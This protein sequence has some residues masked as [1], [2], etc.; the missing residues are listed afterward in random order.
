MM[1]RKTLQWIATILFLAGLGTGGYAYWF[2]THS[3]ENLR[4]AVLKAIAEKCPNADVQ[5]RRAWFDFGRRVH[6]EGVLISAKGLDE[7]LA[8]CAEVVIAIDGEELSEDLRIDVRSV[9]VIRP[10]VRVVRDAKGNWN[11]QKLLPLP[12]PGDACPEFALEDLQVALRIA[13]SEGE[14]AAHIQK[15]ELRLISS[16]RRQFALEASAHLRGLGSIH[17]D[18]NCDLNKKTW[19]VNGQ[20]VEAANLADLVE[21]VSKAAPEVPERVAAAARALSAGSPEFVQ[22]VQTASPRQ[23]AADRIVF[24]GRTNVEFQLSRDSA[25]A[26]IVYKT[27]LTL[28][29]AEVEHPALPFALQRVSGQV[30]AD[31]HRIVIKNVQATGETV[32][33][34]V[35]G[36]VD[37]PSP[38]PSNRLDFDVYD[39]PLDERLQARLPAAARKLARSIHPAGRID[40]K[41]S[42]VRT[43]RGWQ[44]ANWVLTAKDCT[45]FHEKFPYPIQDIC[46]KATQSGN[47]FKIDLHGFGGGRPIKLAG[48][49]INP[50]AEA[51]CLYEIDVGRVPI[52]DTLMT[53]AAAQ[54]HLYKTLSALRLRGLISARARFHRPPGPDK[55]VEWRLAARVINGSIEFE[56]FPY[57]IADLTGNVNF[58]SVRGKWTFTELEGVHGPGR[59]WGSGTFVKGSPADPGKLLL[60]ISTEQ[61]PIENDLERSF[62]SSTQKLWNLIFPTGRLRADV[63][64]NWT[65]GS[66]AAVT[67]PFARLTN[68]TLEIKSFPYPLENVS[69]RFEF[70]RD[71]E[72]ACDRLTILE[73]KAKHDGTSIAIDDER[74]GAYVLC[75][76]A[77]DP[78]GEWQ[79]RLSNL[80]VDDLVPDRTLQHALP[81][82][83]RKTLQALQPQGSV[84]LRG[85]LHL[86]GTRSGNYP[87]TAAWDYRTILSG[88][89]IVAGIE[90]KHVQGLVN[91]RGKWDGSKVEMD[92]FLDLD[93]VFVL[94][95]HFTKVKGPFSLR[96]Q[97]LTVGSNRMIR[98]LAAGA[99]EP[100]VPSD[101][102]ISAEAVHG[103]FFLDAAAHLDGQKTKYRVKAEM[104]NASLEEYARLNGLGPASLRGV[105]SGWVDLAGDSS[106]PKDVA[107][108]GQLLINP[109]A[110]YELPVFVQIFKAFSFAPPD[111]TAFNYALASYRIGNRQVR[112]DGIDLIG[113]ALSLRGRGVARFD[114][115]LHLEFYSQ[116]PRNRWPVIGD[117]LAPFSKGWLGVTVTGTVQN[118][119]AKY[120]PIPEVDKTLRTFLDSF[121]PRPGPPP[122]LTPSWMTSVPR[123]PVISPRPQ[124]AGPTSEPR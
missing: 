118:P 32:R 124:A 79:L 73:F 18:G 33:L 61:I 59:L 22:T 102:R 21:I 69:G 68:G 39:L 10:D 87:V 105:M 51:E 58:D 78:I 94:G 37:L 11:W 4:R 60:K 121:N 81:L 92:G 114:G 3:D 57:R 19:T 1:V 26:E 15:A 113:D 2:F 117:M 53:A 44:P 67:V 20:T 74:G 91:S 120:T 76:E 108:Q 49:V 110:L 13:R 42:L 111:K 41:G 45:A 104:R 107:G 72:A 56:K 36:R 109:A 115:T 70:G 55:K 46:G 71:P 123:F 27:L 97:E 88:A 17:L 90:L 85:M 80:I 93:S 100:K 63:L 52:N 8:R 62:P 101:E 66:K 65:P 116:M 98:P 9:R 119:Y 77:D 31:A 25:A 16:A 5:V 99:S 112:F 6:L 50:G 28:V 86:R 29:D 83:V 75:P 84:S 23:A 106:N 30:Y 122:P 24:G 95:Q 38:A 14:F 89:T 82:G 103:K 64:V 96:D 7:P 35:N 48:T 34:A 54:P 47:C 40:A 12:E 43:E